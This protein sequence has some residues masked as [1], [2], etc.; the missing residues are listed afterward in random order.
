MPENPPGYTKIQPEYYLELLQRMGSKSKY[1]VLPPIDVA[2]WDE[3]VY[4]DTDIS[5]SKHYNDVF[6]EPN[7]MP[8]LRS[9]TLQIA[10]IGHNMMLSLLIIIFYEQGLKGLDVFTFL[11][12]LVF[13]LVVLLFMFLKNDIIRF[14]RQAQMI[15]MTDGNSSIS[16]PWR[17]V[18]GFLLSEFGV[19]GRNDIILA[20]PYQVEGLLDDS[21]HYDPFNFSGAFD[22]RDL[23]STISSIRRYEF[24]RRY[25]EKGLKAIQPN[26]PNPRIASGFSVNIPKPIIWFAIPFNWFTLKP[27]VDKWFIHRAATMKWPEEIEALCKPG[28]DLTGYDTGVVKSRPDL[29]YRVSYE[30]GGKVTGYVDAQGR[31]PNNL[32]ADIL[33]LYEDPHKTPDT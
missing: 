27:L 7:V 4:L 28:A 3:D 26:K 1:S 24:I 30:H 10:L 9:W 2:M 14:N 33:K 32:P 25:M 13:L 17:E 12:Y 21:I 6:I 20:L 18:Q 11:F 5:D 29:F 22:E 15:H 16:F 8:G 19:D 23:Y 31:G